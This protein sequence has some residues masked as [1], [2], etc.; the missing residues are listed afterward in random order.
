MELDVRERLI[1]LSILPQEGNF[2]TLKVMRQ[3]RE[4]LSFNEE[5]LKQ[6]SFVQ[7]E[8]RVTWDD[9]VEQ[10]KEIEIGEKA[11]DIIKESLKKLN[12]TKKL[13]DEHYTI[14]EKFMGD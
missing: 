13:K 8:D 10:V 9:K 14:Y 5:E 12:E 1:L 3:L 6:Y 2:I 11:T 4:G 7:N